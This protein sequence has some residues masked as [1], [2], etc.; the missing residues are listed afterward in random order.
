MQYWMETKYFGD[1]EELYLKDYPQ[2]FGKFPE[3]F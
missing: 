2:E 3:E 1:V